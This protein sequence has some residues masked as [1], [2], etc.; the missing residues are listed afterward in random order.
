[1][2]IEI[3]YSSDVDLTEVG[4]QDVALTPKF[5]RPTS[6]VVIARGKVTNSHGIVLEEFI[7]SVSGTTGKISKSTRAPSVVAAIDAPAVD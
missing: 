3:N 1:M 4:T 6:T 5:D 7:L 2:K